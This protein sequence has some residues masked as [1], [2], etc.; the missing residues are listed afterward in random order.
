MAAVVVVGGFGI[1]KAI[2]ANTQSKTVVSDMQANKKA[3]KASQTNAVKKLNNEKLKFK[4]DQELKKKQ[5]LKSNWLAGKVYKLNIATVDITGTVNNS[6]EQDLALPDPRLNKPTYIVFNPDAS[7]KTFIKVN[8]LKLA[9]KARKQ[10]TFD[11]LDAKQRNVNFKLKGN[12]LT[13]ELPKLEWAYPVSP[14]NAIQIS[15]KGR[16]RINSI[17]SSVLTNVKLNKKSG[18]NS[19]KLNKRMKGNDFSNTTGDMYVANY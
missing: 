4:K 18:Q 19:Y 11:T 12:T 16:K 3:K 13:A 17:F 9:K 15:K 6:M 7:Q 8:S 14:Y 10:N 1:N 5:M 2:V